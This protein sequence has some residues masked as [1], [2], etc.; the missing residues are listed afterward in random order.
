M[1]KETLVTLNLIKKFVK[2]DGVFESYYHAPYSE[3]E[4]P[5]DVRIPYKVTKISLH[6]EKQ[7]KF[8][9]EGVVYVKPLEVLQGVDGQFETG[10][11]LDDIPEYL[12]D[13]FTESIVKDVDNYL[14]HVYL[15]VDFTY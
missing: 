13:D 15:E 11:S 4:F 8:K 3:N 12:L 14:N 10:Y 1:D 7:G 9:Y 5:I 6:K 2:S